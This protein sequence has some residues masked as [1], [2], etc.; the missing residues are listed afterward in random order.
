[1]DTICCFRPESYR[2][3]ELLKFR[4]RPRSPASLA[5]E[6]KTET[7]GKPLLDHDII[8]FLKVYLVAVYR[9]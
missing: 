7:N 5:N 4:K 8:T 2:G 3:G 6:D 9:F 1:M